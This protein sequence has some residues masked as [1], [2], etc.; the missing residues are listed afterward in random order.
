VENTCVL[1]YVANECLEWA[2]L[3]CVEEEEE[4]E[5]EEV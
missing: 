3:N 1:G 5:E 4:E 2:P